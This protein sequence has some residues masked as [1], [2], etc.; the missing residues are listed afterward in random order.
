MEEFGFG[1]RSVMSFI[2]LAVYAKACGDLSLSL[3]ETVHIRTARCIP[4]L[5]QEKAEPGDH[6]MRA[7]ASLFAAIA[8]TP[9]AKRIQTDR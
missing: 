4:T 6:N 5:L 8:P 2:Y 1:C 3:L 9:T 7:H